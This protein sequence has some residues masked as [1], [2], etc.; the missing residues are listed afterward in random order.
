MPCKRNANHMIAAEI[1]QK[2]GFDGLDIYGMVIT[3][4]YWV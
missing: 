4:A 3:A 2:F 1:Q